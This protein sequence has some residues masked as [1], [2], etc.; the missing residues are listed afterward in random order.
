[1]V[2]SCFSSHLVVELSYIFS[3]FLSFVFLILLIIEKLRTIDARLMC[4]NVFQL[5]LGLVPRPWSCSSL[6]FPK[7][8]DFADNGAEEASRE[9][10]RSEEAGKGS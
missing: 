1:M 3:F 6:G 4:I 9:S 8:H 10:D 7:P 2:L 5:F